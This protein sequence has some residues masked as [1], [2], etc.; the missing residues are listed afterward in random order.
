MA[1]Q[2]N[3][4]INQGSNFALTF[5]VKDSGGVP[6]DLTGYSARMMVRRDYDKPAVL[7][8]NSTV[9]NVAITPLE[10][11]VSISFPP[12]MTS[13]IRFAG[14]SLDCVYDV[15]I[16]TSDSNVTRVLE[17]TV[18]ISREVTRV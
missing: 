3:F 17:G 2:Y 12:S 13:P 6:Y 10:G 18:T 14:E 8:A 1:G 4:T 5:V 15:E 7:T 11:K 9:G 16:Y